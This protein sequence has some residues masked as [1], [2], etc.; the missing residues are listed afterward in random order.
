MNTHQTSPLSP[1]NALPAAELPTPARHTRARAQ[2]RAPHPRNPNAAPPGCERTRP[3]AEKRRSKY[4]IYYLSA[5]SIIYSP[6]AGKGWGEEA[7][8]EAAFTPAIQARGFCPDPPPH[9]PRLLPASGMMGC[10]QHRPL[11]LTL[12]VGGCLLPRSFLP[13]TEQGFPPQRAPIP[14]SRSVP[15]PEAADPVPKR[16]LH[17]P[18]C[19]AAAPRRGLSHMGTQHPASLPREPASPQ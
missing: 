11:H 6:G 1:R 8:A 18:T 14:S 19:R 12:L 15:V 5:L 16:G 3:G 2:R 13:S 17:Q 10:L 7:L 9:C 4:K